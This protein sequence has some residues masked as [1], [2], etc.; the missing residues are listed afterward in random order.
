MRRPTQLLEPRKIGQNSSKVEYLLK[1]RRKRNRRKK[2]MQ[3]LQKKRKNLRKR[4][5]MKKLWKQI[6]MIF[7]KLTGRFTYSTIIR[8]KHVQIDWL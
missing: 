1:K 2:K 4:K 3:L 8:E 7:G 5:K 6:R